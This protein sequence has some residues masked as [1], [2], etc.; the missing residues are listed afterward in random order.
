MKKTLLI[1]GVMLASVLNANAQ[2]VF[3]ADFN[4]GALAPWTTID[5][6]GDG[7]NWSVVQIQDE[8]GAPVG[9]PVLRSASWQT[10]ALTPNN[11]VFSPAIDLS[12]FFPGSATVALTWEVMAIDAA[13]DLERYTCYVTTA[14][15]VAA[16]LASGTTL[17]EAS[18]AG[19]NSLTPRTLD[20][21][22][23]LGEAAVYIVFRHFG[24]SDQFTME[25]DN[26]AVT[27]TPLST[28]SFFA[29]NFKVYPNPA[30]NVLNI[31]AKAN[32]SLTNVELTDLNGRVVKA[33]DVS[34]VSTQLNISD[35]NAGMYF[36]KVTSNEGVGT[37]KIIK[38]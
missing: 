18:L 19:V 38:K 31:D 28:E 32:M 24:V 17:Y 34:G 35:V 21:S 12:G 36:L 16:A 7:R 9:T 15:T 30:Q 14:P 26:V 4:D 20:I 1:A 29:S 10:V 3:S 23:F 6:D 11:Y 22:S 8:E 37:S 5:A 33:M 13:W 27:A 2:V 25:I